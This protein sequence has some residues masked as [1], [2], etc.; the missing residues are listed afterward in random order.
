MPAGWFGKAEFQTG[1]IVIPEFSVSFDQTAVVYTVA[2]HAAISHLFH[3][4]VTL[5]FFKFFICYIF[6]GSMSVATYHSHCC[7]LDTFYRSGAHG[8]DTG[9][10]QCGKSNCDNGDEIPSSVC[11]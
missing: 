10:E 9:K 3:K 6:D 7:T 2:E 8:Q 5:Y 1:V 11:M 4:R